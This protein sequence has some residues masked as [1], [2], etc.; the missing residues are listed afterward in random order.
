MTEGPKSISPVPRRE[1]LASNRGSGE[2]YAREENYGE[3]IG[4]KASC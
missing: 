3:L 1:K 2:R 4:E